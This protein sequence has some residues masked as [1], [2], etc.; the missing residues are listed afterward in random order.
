MH[1]VVEG[2]TPG[3]TSFLVMNPDLHFVV[4]MDVFVCTA[5][6]GNVLRTRVCTSPTILQAEVL[7]SGLE[8]G[9]MVAFSS[10]FFK[11]H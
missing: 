3:N 6:M 7:W 1:T 11:E 2:F 4:A 9:M 8:F 10:K 5:G